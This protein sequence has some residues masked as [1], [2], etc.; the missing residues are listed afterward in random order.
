MKHTYN[1]LKAI[2]AMLA[3]VAGADLTGIAQ[4]M[5][6]DIAKWVLMVPTVSA[7]VLHTIK[8]VIDL[9][10]DGEINGSFLGLLVI[11]AMCLTLPSCKQFVP[12]YDVTNNSAEPILMG[13]TRRIPAEDVTPIFDLPMPEQLGGGS[14]LIPIKPT[15]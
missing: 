4:I 11:G 13:E 7:A 8:T 2:A 6:D 1:A 5:P 10:D 12:A 15:K 14:I 3:T 9:L